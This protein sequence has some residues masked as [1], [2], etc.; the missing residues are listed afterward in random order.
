MKTAIS[1]PDDLF[2]SAEALATR[3]GVSRSQL[4]ADA[5]RTYLA[6]RQDE[7]IRAALDAAHGDAPE[8]LEEGLKRAQAKT[9]EASEW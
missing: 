3:L 4:Y 1:L 5:L 8:P 9:L 2:D 7:A 6:W